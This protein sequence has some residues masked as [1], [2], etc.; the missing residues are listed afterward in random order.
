MLCVRVGVAVFALMSQNRTAAASGVSDPSAGHASHGTLA[1][2][3]PMLRQTF[4]RGPSREILHEEYA[5]KGRIDELAP[6]KTSSDIYIQAPVERVW[7]L[8]IDLRAWPTID[9]AIRSV[10]LATAVTV[11]THFSFVLNG[12][13]IHAT[14]AIVDPGRELTWTGESLWFRSIDIHRLEPAHDS[15]TRLYIAESF[16]GVLASVF[17]T[18]VQLKAQHDKWLMA[19]KRAAESRF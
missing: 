5:K 10:S 13:P 1:G 14:I 19:F 6:V 12:F 2:L 16:A 3:T 8:L 7:K 9:T 18:S 17:I 15:G 11:D 4:Y